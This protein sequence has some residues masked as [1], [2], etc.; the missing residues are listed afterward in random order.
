MFWRGATICHAMFAIMPL[1][2]VISPCHY[3]ALRYGLFAIVAAARHTVAIDA[4]L[5]LQM[6]LAR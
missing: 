3:G 1:L 2:P 6:M 4:T 5:C